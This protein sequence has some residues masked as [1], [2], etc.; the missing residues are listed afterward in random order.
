M[1]SCAYPTQTPLLLRVSGDRLFGDQLVREFTDWALRTH[2]FDEDDW[3]EG[4]GWDDS[5]DVTM[6]LGRTLA[7]LWLLNFSAPNSDDE[8][9]RSD[10]LN[11]ARRYVRVNADELLAR[12]GDG[13]R[14]ARA[15]DVLG[16]EWTE[17]YIRGGFFY[18]ANVP[19]R[20]GILLHEARHH[21]GSSHDAPFPADSVYAGRDDGA[22][23]SWTYDGAFKYEALYLARFADA[24]QIPSPADDPLRPLILRGRA[25]SAANFIL[26][27]CFE[28]D[29]GFRFAA[30]PTIPSVAAT[31][32]AAGRLD[33]FVRG[34]EDR[35][36][37]KWSGDRA[38]WGPSSEGWEELGGILASPPSVVSWG[39][40]RLD[41]FAVGTDRGL[42]HK[43]WDGTWGP[44]D[45]DWEY[46]GGVVVGSP[47]VV[48][49]G[50]NRIDVFVVGSDFA[51]HHKWFDGTGWRPSL[52][53]WEYQGGVIPG[54]HTATC[55]GAGR[56]DLFAV[57]SDFQ[58]Y[59]KAFDGTHWRPS[60]TGWRSLG[61]QIVGQPTVV[62]RGP[63]HLDV[64]VLGTDRALYRKWW[65]GAAW[66]PSRLG[67]WEPLGGTVVGSPAVAP[68]APN[69]LDVFVVST[70]RA[71]YH[72]ALVG[73]GW[74]PSPSDW[75]R[76]GGTIVGSPTV[77]SSGPDRVDVFVAGTDRGVYQGSSDGSSLPSIADW[78][79]LG[80]VFGRAP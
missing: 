58:L 1:A 64:F 79:Y 66:R 36:Y 47:T 40:D 39:A 65:D 41:V 80:P 25:R 57:G 14:A 17:L 6:P 60:V 26:D 32:W 16:D 43:W 67:P 63:D 56:I 73:T 7:A 71:L 48:S 19:R 38:T 76:L 49:W 29:P 37:H 74:L 53:G 44:S 54:L 78:R 10:I 8:D 50:R 68:S 61:G 4:F 75:E 69:R 13:S 5:F 11:W 2:G 22:D 46:Q 28:R 12:C 9:Y 52:T 77:V 21:G 55:W 3:N 59:H 24:G 31:S 35:M 18:T 23:S 72:K 27:N 30:P 62:S 45:A 20:A 15:M 34:A 42:N 33:L 70:D 51:L